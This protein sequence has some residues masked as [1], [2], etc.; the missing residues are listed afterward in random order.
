MSPPGRTMSARAKSPGRR[1]PVGFGTS[2]STGSERDC[3]FRLAPMRFTS[4]SNARSGNAPTWTRTFLPSSTF[5]MS[6]SATST[7]RRS[8]LSRT[9]TTTTLPTAAYSPGATRFSA[10][11]PSNGARI[12]ASARCFVERLAAALATFSPANDC[13]ADATALSY[14]AF[15]CSACER[16]ESHADWDIEPD[17]KSDFVRSASATARSIAS[18]EALTSGTLDGSKWSFGPSARRARAC[19]CV[20]FACA[21]RKPASRGSS[22]TRMSP[23]FTRMPT[24]T[25]TASTAPATWVATSLVSSAASVPDSSI[26]C[27]SAFVVARAILVAI[28]F[29]ASEAGARA[30]SGTGA[31]DFFPHATR[32]VAASAAA[33]SA[34]GPCLLVD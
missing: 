12:A 5:A 29:F 15:D 21:A 8:G 28:G 31:S 33:T 1:M 9:T 2:A 23:F 10:I 32:R 25:F 26:V 13:F 20:A 16:A 22:W 27:G 18:F 30:S 3:A 4:P 11:E 34:R 19:S 17:S 6:A 7:F 14:C 24:S